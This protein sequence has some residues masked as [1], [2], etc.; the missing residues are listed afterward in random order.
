MREN[1][2]HMTLLSIYVLCN[3]Q[4]SV[5]HSRLAFDRLSEFL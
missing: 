4:I 2:A 3:F 5:R 1:G